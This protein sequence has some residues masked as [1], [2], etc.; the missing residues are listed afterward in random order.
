MAQATA[1][2]VERFDEPGG[3]PAAEAR[4]ERVGMFGFQSVRGERGRGEVLQVRGDDD[5]GF[6]PDGGGEDVAVAWIGQFEG[7]NEVLESGD[8][9]VVRVG[10]HEAPGALQ[11]HGREVRPAA[12]KR[13]GPL[14]MDASGPLR[15]VEVR[16]GEFEQQIAK[17]RR[18]QDGGIE[19]GDCDRQGLIAHVQFLGVGG[20]LVERAAPRSVRHVL[21]PAQVLEP[22]AAVRADL[23]ERDIARFQKADQ[24]GPRDVQV[25]GGLLRGQF[26]V[27]AQYGDGAAGGHVLEDLQEQRSH[28]RRELDGLPDVVAGDTERQGTVRAEERGEALTGCAGQFGVR[29]RR[30]RGAG[31]CGHGVGHAVVACGDGSACAG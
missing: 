29:R 17:R 1:D 3:P 15:S 11:A 6:G 28:R 2:S 23:A 5:V 13:A 9:D 18:V 7:W 19:E 10:V 21:V 26:G 8:Q 20:E 16:D 31:V 4:E 12:E 22:H 27:P 30:R 24:E 25:V 14:V